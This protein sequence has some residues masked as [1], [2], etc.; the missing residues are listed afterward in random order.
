MLIIA[1]FIAVFSKSEIHI[2]LNQLHTS[3]FDIFFKYLTDLGDGMAIVLV[4]LI[5]VFFSKRKSLQVALSGIV[6]GIIAQF[7]KKVVFGATPR[8]SAYFEDLNIPLHYI[9]G[10]DLHTAFSFPSG[11]STAIFTLM[12][13][14]VLISNKPKLDILF[15]TLASIVAFSR[16]YLSQHFL[17]DIYVGSIL[18]I[19]SSLM[20]YKWLYYSQASKKFGLDKPLFNFKTN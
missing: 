19:L 1:P 2:N 12:T 20:V 5:L 10:V 4:V 13:S 18:G 15:I 14:L 17:G 6:S 11:H 8:P 9:E 7:L 3:W 16:V